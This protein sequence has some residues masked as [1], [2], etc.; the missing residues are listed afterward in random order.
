MKC[1]AATKSES[2]EKNKNKI[3]FNDLDRYVYHLNTMAAVLIR[4]LRIR[5]KYRIERLNMRGFP[6]LNVLKNFAG[7]P[8]QKPVNIQSFLKKNFPC[9]VT[10]WTT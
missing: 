4:N 10:K 8:V 6:V 2:I 3:L 7:Y 9:S 5:K 1:L